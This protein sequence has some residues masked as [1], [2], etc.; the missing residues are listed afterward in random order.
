[1]MDADVGNIQGSTQTQGS[2]WACSPREIFLN[3]YDSYMHYF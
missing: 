3:I 1:M 2:P